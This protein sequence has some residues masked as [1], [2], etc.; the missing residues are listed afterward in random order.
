[1]PVILALIVILTA[2][3]HTPPLKPAA[4]EHPIVSQCMIMDTQGHLRWSFPSWL[5]FFLPDGR[6]IT[7]DTDGLT[8]RGRNIE[9]LWHKKLIPHHMISLAANGD[10]LTFTSEYHSIAKQRAKFKGA[11]EVDWRVDTRQMKP[12]SDEIARQKFRVDKILRLNQ[13]GRIV[14]QMSLNDADYPMPW[15]IRLLRDGAPPLPYESS[16]LNSIYEI[17]ANAS[18][19][20]A[21]KA[22]N[23][24]LNDTVNRT[25][26]IT[27]P[28][29]RKIIW[30]LNFKKFGFSVVHDVSVLPNGNL[31]LFK[32]L[33]LDPLLPSSLEEIDPVTEQV[34]W[35]YE[36]RPPQNF[37]AVRMGS[38]QALRD[39]RIL[40]A[41]TTRGDHRV[42]MI[43]REGNTLW[44]LNLNPHTDVAMQGAYS[45][46]VESFLSNNNSPQVFREDGTLAFTP[47]AAK[48]ATLQVRRYPPLNELEARRELKSQSA[49]L[50]KYLAKQIDPYLGEATVSSACDIPNA[51]QD[52]IREN[53]RE[54]RLK[55][56]LVSSPHH[57]VDCYGTGGDRQFNQRLFLYCKKSRALFE[58][59]DYSPMS[60]ALPQ[61][62]LAVC[63]GG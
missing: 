52:H 17:P 43:D 36:S 27:D 48:S 6:F 12:V 61:D 50:R 58:I 39:G 21:F 30:R 34:V 25:I 4:P 55:F 9:K 42:E 57:A 10:I 1:M 15:L 60:D 5:C 44:S 51:D 31:L 49:T 11:F 8:M 23:L 45:W 24:L 14:H 33:M 46:P 41:H 53:E 26:F 54:L 29:L 40:F 19:L 16:H 59:N 18:S 13:N 37:H 63:T 7:G 38:V 3:A 22:G 28:E 32:N 2:C 62:D 47:K 35:R 56:L 20:P